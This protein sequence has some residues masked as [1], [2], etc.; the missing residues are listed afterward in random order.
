VGPTGGD[1]LTKTT[2]I[3]R[4]RTFGGK[5]PSTD[6]LSSLDLGHQAFVP[7]RAD[8]FFYKQSPAGGTN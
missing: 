8:Y 5:A 4:I 7:Y 1:R 3:Q 2:F 6:C